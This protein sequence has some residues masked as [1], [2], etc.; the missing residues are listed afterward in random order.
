MLDYARCAGHVARHDP[1]TWTMATLSVWQPWSDETSWLRTKANTTVVAE[2]SL[3]RFI[4]AR[5]LR[6]GLKP[7]CWCEL[8]RG[9]D[10]WGSAREAF[11]VGEVCVVSATFCRIRSY[12][13][14]HEFRQSALPERITR[15]GARN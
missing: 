7:M 12:T 1:W 14:G 10:W 5:A 11:D 2:E 6:D 3:I 8:A 4:S 13:D 9:A 15:S